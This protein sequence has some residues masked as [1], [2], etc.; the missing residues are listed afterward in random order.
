M[1]V[2]QPIPGF[3]VCLLLSSHCGASDE[4]HHEPDLKAYEEVLK[5]FVRDDGRVD[6]AGLKSARALDGFVKQLADVSPDS[7]PALFPSRE[8]RLAY[9]INAYNALVLH[10]FSREYPEKRD[11]LTTKVG[12]ALF[13]YG[14]KHQVGGVSR[15]LADIEDHSI[16][17]MGDPRIHFAIVCA[18]AGCP[19]LSRTPYTAATLDAHLEAETRK[20]FAATR[21]FALDSAG[22]EVRL[23]QILE[24]F[25]ADFGGSSKNVLDFVARYRGAEAKQL[26]SGTWKLRYTPYDWSA[27]DIRSTM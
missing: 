20:Y 26:R 10:S 25:K 27:N 17:N 3:A 7:N 6:Y 16:R 14:M 24:W 19:A 8:A 13:F 5:K 21:S 1:R 11:R 18:S 23:P 12:R 4:L 22:R 9:W 2:T 15:S